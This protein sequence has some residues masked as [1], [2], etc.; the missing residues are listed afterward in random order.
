V[1][2]YKI[3]S[4]SM[5]WQKKVIAAPVKYPWEEQEKYSDENKNVAHGFL[6]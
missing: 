3:Y 2:E 6:Q 1:S 5:E 4:A